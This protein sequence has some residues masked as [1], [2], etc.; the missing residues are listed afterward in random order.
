MRLKLTQAAASRLANLRARPQ[1]M[2]VGVLG[3]GVVGKAMALYLARRGAFV[4]GADLRIGIDDPELTA[5]GVEL[6]LGPMTARTFADVDLLAVSPGADPRQPAVQAVLAGD[7]P[8]IGELELVG[9]IPARVIAITGTNGKSTTT[10]LTGALVAAAGYRAFVGG[11]LGDPIVSWIDSGDPAEV[12]VL[13]LSSYQL[14]TAYS[15]SADAGV[16]LNVTPD[17]FERYPDVEDYADTKQ[18]LV[19]CSA[20]SILNQDDPRVVAMAGAARD[21]LVWFSTR[22]SSV[23]G[24][25][26]VLAGD[27]VRGFGSAEL[28]DGFALEHP[29]L[30][31][32]H[33]REDALA[34]L[35]ACHALG[36]LRQD[37]LA[38]VR[39]GYVAFAGLEHRLE[40]VG[41][42]RG[43]VFINDSKATN[44]ESAAVAVGA[45]ERPV[46]LLA[47]GRDKGTGYA[48]LAE[49]LPGRTRQVVAY[50]EAG[51]SIAE[52]LAGVVPVVRVDSM[53]Q[54]FERAVAGARSGDVVLLAPACSS[55][56]EFDNYAERGRTFKRLVAELGS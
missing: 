43:V 54:A 46:V 56:D 3:L 32:R 6:R 15:F 19:E 12:A 16:V 37:N 14:E 2:R 44:D 33:N 8:V 27:R 35:L 9:D 48:R 4:A 29:R 25:G 17:H 11:N 26:A 50:G 41:E 10:A 20:V 7:R 13:E 31:G 22:A 38:A 39:D 55:F 53:A 1:Q 34:A 18:R 40:W 30:F 21:R 28:L 51:D 23:P 36:L 47:G 52:A 24:D 5:A 45:M 49:V 42:R